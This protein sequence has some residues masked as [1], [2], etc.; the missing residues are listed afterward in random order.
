MSSFSEYVVYVDESGDHS[1]KNIDTDYPIFVLTFS[2]FHKDKYINNI[3]P[4]FQKFKFKYFGHD[5]IIFHENEI[6]RRK[7]Q[8]QILYNKIIHSNF[9]HELSD[10]IEESEFKVISSVIHKEKLKQN[11]SKS[12]NVYHTALYFCLERLH[13]FLQ[14]NNNETKITHIVV[15]KRGKK[16]DDELELEFRRICQDKNYN[17]DIIL[18]DKKIN[19]VGLQLSDM[20]ARPIGRHLIDPNEGNRAY[21]II[22]TKFVGNGV[23]KDMGLKI[24]P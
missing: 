4:N 22:E 12:G 19:S 14:S 3:V 11:N 15:E 23:S 10:I 20:I 18:A 7:N 8:F 6:R 1:L 5:I 24:F 16:E 21:D 9:M 13:R 17:F 2:I